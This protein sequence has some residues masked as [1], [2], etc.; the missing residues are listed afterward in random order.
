M[1]VQIH[2]QQDDL[3]DGQ[4]I[5]LLQEHQQEMFAYSP[6]ESNHALDGSAFFDSG[7]TLWSAW[8]E[9]KLAGCGGMIDLGQ[10]QA[11]LKG[12]RTKTEFLR[13]GVSR[14]LLTTIMAEA[15]RRGYVKISLETGT[16]VAFMPSR[17]LYK[18]MGF[19]ECAPFA[20]YVLD[21]HSVF[22]E[23]AL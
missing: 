8:I 22:F 1:S 12:M 9:G 11:E 18:S 14:A 19:S 6:P 21:P 23:F 17:E 15:R 2:I 5:Q 7:L 20:H 4:V 13:Q 10:G 3:K 16:H